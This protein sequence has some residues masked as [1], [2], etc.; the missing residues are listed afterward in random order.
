MILKLWEQKATT[1]N[2]L[3]GTDFPITKD[4]YHGKVI[5]IIPQVGYV[6]K[7]LQPPV[8]YII[9][10]II[11]GV[12]IVREATKKKKITKLDDFDFNKSESNEEGNGYSIDREYI[13]SNDVMNLENKSAEK[14]DN[15][16]IKSD[17]NIPEFFIDKERE[18]EEKKE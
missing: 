17:E 14:P 5:H 6:T 9:I 7:I 18:S 15:K 3:V 13:E 2:H 11:V 1:I 8:N 4:L 10:A 12:I 16:K